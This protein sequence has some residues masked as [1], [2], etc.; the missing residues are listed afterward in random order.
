MNIKTNFTTYSDEYIQEILERTKV[1][2]MVGLSANWNRPSYFAAK[3]LQRKGYKIIPINSKEYGKKILDEVVYANLND[4]KMKVDMVDI[5]RKQAAVK[6]I[7][8]DAISIGTKTI[9][10]QLGIVDID[11]AKKAKTNNIDVIMDRCPKIEYARLSGELGW[12]GIN[13]LQITNKR[14]IIRR[15]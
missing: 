1:I 14:R 8:D 11:A 4:L 10:M 9:W 3:Y 2:A 7:V 13:T 15:K 5:F 12:G 6:S